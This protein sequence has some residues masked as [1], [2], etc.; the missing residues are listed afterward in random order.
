MTSDMRELIDTFDAHM[1]SARPVPPQADPNSNPAPEAAGE[2]D[3]PSDV[4]HSETRT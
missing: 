2:S 4:A 3:Q 1:P